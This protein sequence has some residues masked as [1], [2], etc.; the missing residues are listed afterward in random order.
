MQALA[1]LGV[2]QAALTEAAGVEDDR[3]SAFLSK[4]VPWHEESVLIEEL[5]DHLSDRVMRELQ[6]DYSESE[7]GAADIRKKKG[8]Y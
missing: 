4:M 2:Q 1:E 3:V 7:E 5:F 8:A 6:W